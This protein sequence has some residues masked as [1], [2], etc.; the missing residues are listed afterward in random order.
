MKKHVRLTGP[1]IIFELG[2]VAVRVRIDMRSKPDVE[3]MGKHGGRDVES[4]T[5]D[6]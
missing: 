1:R 3:Y 5:C 6:E 2:H 4:Y